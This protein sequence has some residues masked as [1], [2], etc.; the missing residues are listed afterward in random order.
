MALGC[1]TVLGPADGEDAVQR[2]RLLVKKRGS[3]LTY[4]FREG[5][6]LTHCQVKF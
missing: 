3:T 2:N 1:A 4:S 5:R 6:S